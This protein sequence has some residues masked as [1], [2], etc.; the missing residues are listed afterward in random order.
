MTAVLHSRPAPIVC[1]DGGRTPMAQPATGENG[2]ETLDLARDTPP[3]GFKFNSEFGRAAELVVARTYFGIT[4]RDMP[5]LLDV[6]PATYQRWE[7]GRDRIP[8]GLWTDL[9]ELYARFDREVGGILDSI[10]DG[11]AS[12][13]VL[14]RR[15]PGPDQPY[16]AWRM[17]VVSEA[18][19]E[20]DRV[21]PVFPETEQA[22]R[23]PAAQLMVSRVYLGLDYREMRE[24]LRV[25]E[26]AY[27]QFEYGL[28]PIPPEVLARVERMVAE[29]DSAV[30]LLLGKVPDDAEVFP[31]IVRRAASDNHRYPGRWLRVVGEAVREDPRIRP[32]FPEDLEETRT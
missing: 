31:V 18:M 24:L 5:T 4:R 21:T 32:R 2:R 8:N 3:E 15:G 17:R 6:R 12:V 28:T 7:N 20:D 1:E 16:P 13:P 14:V 22:G 30:E 25:G 26:E 11:A 27:R 9:D 23:D 19:Q 10:P 29:F